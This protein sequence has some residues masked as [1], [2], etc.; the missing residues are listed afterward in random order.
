[1]ARRRK[2]Q[3]HPPDVGDHMVELESGELLFF[4]GSSAL[5]EASKC[6]ESLDRPC[7]VY[8]YIGWELRRDTTHERKFRIKP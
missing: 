6:A 7:R 4:T 3:L 5:D 2:P 1:M 8:K